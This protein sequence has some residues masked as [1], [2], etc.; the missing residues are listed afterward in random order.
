[1]Q[2]NYK[3]LVYL[4]L[5]LYFLNAC[6]SEVSY[7]P[8][9][10]DILFQ[11]LDCGPLCDAIESVTQSY[12]NY[13]FSH[14]GLVYHRKDDSLFVIEAIGEKVTLTPFN[15][16]ISRSMNENNKPKV[17]AMRSTLQPTLINK[18][19]ELALNEVGAPYDDYFMPDNNKWYCSELIAFGFNTAA[20]KIIFTNSPMTYKAA[21]TDTIHP[22]WKAYFQELETNVPEGL[23]GCNPGAM[24][25]SE[26][27][28]LVYSFY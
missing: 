22:A 23:P 26:Y 5:L 11:D 18:A 10:G 4:S 2:I 12:A 14:M 3:Q 16:F 13:H 15:Q 19:V 25:R 21:G 9:N 28:K 27:L 24:S 17:I 7:T 20:H 6:S 1:M 8:Q